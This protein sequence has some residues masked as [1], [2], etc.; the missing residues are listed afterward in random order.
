[1]AEYPFD[2]NQIQKMYLFD[3]NIAA[4]RQIT[5]VYDPSTPQNLRRDF[6]MKSM[7]S[8][9][10]M[11]AHK[12]CILNNCCPPQVV[13]VINESASNAR[14]PMTLKLGKSYTEA[15]TVVLQ[16]PP[17]KISSLSLRV[18]ANIASSNGIVIWKIELFKESANGEISENGY[19]TLY[20]AAYAKTYHK[21]MK[22]TIIN[23]KNLGFYASPQEAI[24]NLKL[25]QSGNCINV[26]VGDIVTISAV[27]IGPMSTSDAN[28]TLSVY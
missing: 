9:T 24:R 21:K 23:S 6:C 16:E 11:M 26:I 5:P 8:F 13:Q 19:A 7:V 12:G 28:A 15:S 18:D 27:L 22:R 20:T 2:P 3:P 25:N 17:R 4:R 14:L 10:E 1:M